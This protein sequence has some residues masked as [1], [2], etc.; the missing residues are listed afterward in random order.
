MRATSKIRRASALS[1][2]VHASCAL[3]YTKGG[4]IPRHPLSTS[5]AVVRSA[6]ASVEPPT[7]S[8]SASVS[9]SM[10]FSA[11][12]ALSRPTVAPSAHVIAPSNASTFSYT[13]IAHGLFAAHHSRW[14]GT[15]SNGLARNVASKSS[16]GISGNCIRSI[17]GDSSSG[18]VAAPSAAFSAFSRN[19][20]WTHPSGACLPDSTNDRM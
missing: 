17:G 6:S 19:S 14:W 2:A 20:G 15:Y 9:A 12:T 16:E 1:G 13:S 5:R 11:P 10:P 7:L 3:E 8:E 18:P 4:A